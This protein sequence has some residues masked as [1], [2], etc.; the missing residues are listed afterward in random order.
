MG[1]GGQMDDEVVSVRTRSRASSSPSFVE[2]VLIAAGFLGLAAS[3]YG[4]KAAGVGLDAFIDIG[5]AA[6]TRSL[7]EGSSLSQ[8]Y[9]GVYYTAEF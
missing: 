9:E 5:S 8:G 1:F 3:A 2:W 7:P 6:E 4:V